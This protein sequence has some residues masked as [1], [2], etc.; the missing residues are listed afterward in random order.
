M[1]S[2]AIS[3][4]QK[5][6]NLSRFGVIVYLTVW[7]IA[8]SGLMF[9]LFL[10]PNPPFSYPNLN[11][12]LGMADFVR[13]YCAAK[14]ADSEDRAQLYDTAMQL[15]VVQSVLH[16]KEEPEAADSPYTPHMC[17][18][19]APLSRLPLINAYWL[20]LAAS[21]TCGAIGMWLILKQHR[22]MDNWTT[23]VIILSIFGT[24]N[25]MNV[26][27][28]GQTTW[29]MF[30]FFCV[31]YWGLA[32]QKDIASGVSFALATIKPQYSF[33]LFAG[34]IAQKK[35]RTLLIFA[36]FTALMLAYAA[37]AL[38]LHNVID[39]PQILSQKGGAEKEWYPKRMCNLRAIFS[40]FMDY[41]IAYKVGF[42]VMF[43]SMP[44][45]YKLWTS[46]GNSQERLRWIFALTILLS[47]ILGPHVNG[48]DCT[49]VGLAAILTL[50]TVSLIEIWKIESKP[51]KVWCILMVAFPAAGWIFGSYNLVF[52]P[53]L[54]A[55]T[56]SG[57]MYVNSPAMKVPKVS[58]TEA[59]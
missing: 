41:G 23:L 19:L 57:F 37:Y 48:Y 43:L 11:G 56:V 38:G 3:N 58:E 15:K 2:G 36:V 47:L 44:F 27:L 54:F 4:F 49:L 16:T 8:Q 35:W 26:L 21:V 59:S 1:T 9:F 52:L 39:Y 28:T 20:W 46:I 31:L 30:L 13:I 55:L 32:N 14:I 6:R 53:L 33:L 42:I 50:P 29:Y 7:L 18:F 17:A 10:S 45:V 25:S 24:I 5:F 34:L 22:K 12:R 51:L 40:H